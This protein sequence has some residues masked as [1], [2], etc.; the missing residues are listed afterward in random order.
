MPEPTKPLS[1]AAASIVPLLLVAAQAPPSGPLAVDPRVF[2]EDECLAPAFE[3]AA[4]PQ[5]AAPDARPTS[6][7]A[8][9]PWEMP[10]LAPTAQPE[11]VLVLDRSVLR[12]GADVTY[13]GDKA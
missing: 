12:E 3:G 9:L 4:C 11:P 7:A 13:A 5:P 10:G 8:L 6:S 2:A 1:R